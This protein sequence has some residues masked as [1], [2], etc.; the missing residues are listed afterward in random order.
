MGD[1]TDIAP[2]ALHRVVVVQAPTADGIED[3]V[4]RRLG[5]VGDERLGAPVAQP[6]GHRGL[7]IAPDFG[8]GLHDIAVS[9]NPA[10]IDP[11]RGLADALLNGLE[12]GDL[13]AAQH[14]RASLLQVV[15]R[16]VVTRS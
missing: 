13:T 7:A 4:H 15:T 6:R 2:G 12:I 3:Q 5:L 10:G 1:R 14:H 16:A 9:Q 8:L 11:G